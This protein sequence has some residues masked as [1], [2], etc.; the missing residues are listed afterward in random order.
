MRGGNKVEMKT[1]KSLQGKR[2]LLRDWHY[3]RDEAVH[4]GVSCKL[5]KILDKGVRLWQ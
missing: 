5:G 3:L 4:C 2:D 1:E